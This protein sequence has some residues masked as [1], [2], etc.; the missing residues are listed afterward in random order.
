M[1]I[2][3]SYLVEEFDLDV[4]DDTPHDCKLILMYQGGRIFYP[5]VVKDLEAQ[6]KMAGI[7]IISSP[8]IVIISKLTVREMLDFASRWTVIRYIEPLRKSSNV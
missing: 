7:G 1:S 3:E 6:G 8:E 2:T 5:E 4:V